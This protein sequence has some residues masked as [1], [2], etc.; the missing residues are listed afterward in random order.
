MSRLGEER[1]VSALRADGR[2]EPP[3]YLSLCSALECVSESATLYNAALASSRAV[4]R[5]YVRAMWQACFGS[6]IGRRYT[7]VLDRRKMCQ[8]DQSRWYVRV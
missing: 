4:L 7:E 1:S 5:D 3:V 2:M 6:F 8:Q